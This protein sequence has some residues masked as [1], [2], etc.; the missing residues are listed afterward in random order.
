MSHGQ[1]ILLRK[2]GWKSKILCGV[3]GGVDIHAIEND[4]KALRRKI[5][6]NL[7][8]DVYNMDETGLFY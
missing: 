3:V 7:P 5:Y 6:D 8:E 2:S 4:I 1:E